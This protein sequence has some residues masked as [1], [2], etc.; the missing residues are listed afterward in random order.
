MLWLRMCSVLIS[1]ASALE[2][3]ATKND[4]PGTQH[5]WDNLFATVYH[6]RKLPRAATDRPARKKSSKEIFN[7]SRLH[8]PFILPAK[9]GTVQTGQGRKRVGR[10]MSICS[11]KEANSGLWSLKYNVPKL[12]ASMLASSH[13]NAEHQP[14]TQHFVSA[15]LYNV[16]PRAIQCWQ[17][18]VF[19]SCPLQTLHTTKRR[20]FLCGAYK[21][22]FP[23]SAAR[24]RLTRNPLSRRLLKL[25][26]LILYGLTD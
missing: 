16:L 23:V 14:D 4:N 18:L 15:E 6:I 11:R 26:I 19:Y 10:N 24:W 7:V 20:P 8:R 9:R 22:V 25:F 2:S 3:V 5:R 17:T 1:G 13:A 12:S 21:T